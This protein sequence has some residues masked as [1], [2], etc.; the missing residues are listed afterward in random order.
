M[1][2]I[3]IKSNQS[4]SVKHETKTK[5]KTKTE[6]NRKRK[7]HRK[8]L[9][10][11]IFRS[12]NPSSISLSFFSNGMFPDIQDRTRKRKIPSVGSFCFRSS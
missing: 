12:K 8:S 11:Q 5:T 10:K 2:P 1:H 9:Q 7:K 4:R 3:H 6:S